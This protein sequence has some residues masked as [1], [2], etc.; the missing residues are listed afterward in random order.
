MCC[1][2]LAVRYRMSM[3]TSLLDQP[4]IGFLVHSVEL[5]HL[6]PLLQFFSPKPF[7]YV[8]L[9]TSL[10][11]CS[12]ASASI[13][14]ASFLEFKPN[15]YRIDCF[16]WM[17]SKHAR[18]C[19]EIADASFCLAGN[20]R[21]FWLGVILTSHSSSAILPLQIFVQACFRCSLLMAIQ[22]GAR[23]RVCSGRVPPSPRFRNVSGL[24][25]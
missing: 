5:H 6:A 4:G 15:A 8:H 10:M 1:P 11:L 25:C 22:L 24:F 9:F 12:T 13:W 17:L 7:V 3:Q 14:L 18:L 19:C 2:P 16:C 20:S 23:P 21:L